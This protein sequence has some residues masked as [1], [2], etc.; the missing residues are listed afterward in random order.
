MIYDSSIVFQAL[1][2]ME[3]KDPPTKSDEEN[4]SVRYRIEPSG[5]K[6]CL[7]KDRPC[8]NLNIG[9]LD[10]IRPDIELSDNK[11]SKSFRCKLL[12]SKIIFINM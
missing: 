12:S 9:L 3:V 11:L 8:I 1:E 5:S 7:E 2:V 10:G 6:A 4:C